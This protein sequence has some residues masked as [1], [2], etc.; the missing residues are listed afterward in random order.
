MLAWLQQLLIT[1]G[2]G[3]VALVVMGESLGLP[4]P[5][6]TLLLLGAAYAGAGYLEVWGIIVAAAVGAIVGDTL[7]YELG[8]WGGR[9][10][11]ERYGPVLH[12]KA[13]HL[14]RA[15]A[16]FARYGAKTVFV[17]R[18]IAVLRTYSALLAGIYR[19]PYR[20]FL[21]FNAAGGLLWALTFGWLG[22][23]FGSQSP[24]IERWAGRAGLL[25]LGLLVLVG[26]VVRLG[27]WA[28]RR[29]RVRAVV[30]AV[31][32]V[33]LIGF[34]RLYLGGHYLRDVLAGYAAG[35]VWLAFT[36]TGVETVQRY[37]WDHA[38]TDTAPARTRS[39]VPPTGE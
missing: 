34:S 32:L 16:F 24:L 8:R 26:V 9:A 5:G 1:Y 2:Y 23:A 25:M 10:L 15:E 37:R 19:L 38:H 28:I 17:G 7:G 13:Q 18:F 11:L 12:L 31:L 14:A 4:L 30:A 20:R 36:I 29:G 22:A 39:S 6:E 33:F 21:L 35:A 3:A 27:R